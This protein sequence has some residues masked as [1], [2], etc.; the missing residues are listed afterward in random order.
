MRLHGIH[1]VGAITRNVQ[2]NYDFYTKILGLKL[3]KSTVDHEDKTARKLYYANYVGKGQSCLVFIERK[4]IGE[5]IPG[6]NKISSTSLTVLS[7][8]SLTFWED[9]FERF[10]VE[11]EGI[12][13]I[14]DRKILPFK[15]FEGHELFLQSLKGHKQ[16]P[17]SSLGN[18][19]IPEKH[20]I[21]GLGPTTISVSQQDQ[22][23]IILEDVLSL[24]HIDC[25]PS[26]KDEKN[27]VYVYSLDYDATSKEIHLEINDLLR[28]GK[29]GYSSLDHLSF[30][31]KDIDELRKWRDL[32]E[33]IRLP[34]S[35]IINHKYY[36]S[37]YFRDGNG[38]LFELSTEEPGFTVDEKIDQ[39]GSTLSLHRMLEKERE[40]IEQNLTPLDL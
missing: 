10:T 15:D 40:T 33:R 11:H 35:G 23:T 9:R 36:Q 37:I 4:N 18:S 6:N 28:E 17:K 30:S 24:R 34:N 1:H 31:V 16:L 2:E 29:L 22:S 14:S 25:Y 21:I 39:L 27:T 13:E 7:D 38:I 3:I 8:E 5:T 32:F 20:T 26:S 12:Q 19:D